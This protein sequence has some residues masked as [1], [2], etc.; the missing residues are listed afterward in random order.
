MTEQE[1]HSLCSKTPSGKILI[2]SFRDQEVR[3]K[4]I[5]CAEDAVVIE[6]NGRSYIWPREL[7]SYQKS[8][9][10]TPSYS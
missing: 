10:A 7:C 5:G 2:F 1:F 9:Y 3:G 8:T 4:F 6:A